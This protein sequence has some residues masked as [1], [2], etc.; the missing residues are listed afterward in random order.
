MYRYWSAVGHTKRQELLE[1]LKEAF[2]AMQLI[3]QEQRH[4]QQARLVQLERR[5]HRQ[6]RL[7]PGND[8]G[9]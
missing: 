2:L 5:H 4:H 3:L 1:E 8:S 7:L 6:A 9:V